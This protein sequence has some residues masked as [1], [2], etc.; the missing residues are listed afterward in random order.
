MLPANTL[1]EV[2]RAG[3]L[4]SFHTGSLVIAKPDGTIV[5]MVGDGSRVIFP[6]SAVKIIQALPLVESGAADHFAMSQ[7]ELAFA[8]ASHSGAPYHTALANGIL[9]RLRLSDAALACGAHLPLGEAYRDALLRAGDTPQR[10]HNNCSGKHAGMLTTAT[11]LGAPQTGYEL[12]AHEVQRRVRK[13]MAEVTE[14]DLSAAVPGID[15]C[16]LPNWPVPVDRLAVAFARIVNGA[17]GAPARQAAFDRLLEACWAAPEAMAGKGRFDTEVLAR[18]G[19][20]VFVKTGAE[21]VH[22]GGIRSA[23][24]GFAV[25]IDD[26]AK[27][28]AEM[29]VGAVIAHFLG[30]GKD[31]GEARIIENAAGLAVGDIRPGSGLRTVLANLAL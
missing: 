13:A 31:L 23:G 30:A 15:G 2:T 12:V 24:I 27:R 8:T 7:E 29:T 19:G 16:S 1:A 9:K 14:T 25:K 20:D 22:C 10:V 21:G 26:G 11:F 18:F 4:E 3:Q 17:D 28:G 6:R 5:A